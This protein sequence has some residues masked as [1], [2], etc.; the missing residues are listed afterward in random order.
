MPS[1]YRQRL[2]QQCDGNLVITLDPDLCLLIYP[3]PVWDAVEVKI[4]ALSSTNRNSRG[5]KRMLLAHAED[6]Q[7]DKSGRVLIPPLLRQLAKLDKQV[8]LAGQ[9]ERFELWDAQAWDQQ[10]ENWLEFQKTAEGQAEYD[11]LSF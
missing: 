4:N 7:I 9:G 11:S 3:L 2:L 1:K 10:R 5:L 6:C 8:V